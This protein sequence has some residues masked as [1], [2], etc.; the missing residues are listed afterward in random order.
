MCKKYLI[1]LLFI[2]ISNSIILPSGYAY[3]A[4][5]E[6]SHDTTITVD[7]FSNEIPKDIFITLIY[8]YVEKA[9]GDYYSKFMT[10]LPGEDPWSYMILNIKK[11]PEHN[12]SYIISLE[13]S[14]YVGP[15]L[16][17]GTDH[18]TLRID[19]SGV[20]IEKFEHI[21]SY[22]LPPHYQNILKGKWPA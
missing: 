21:K 2:L 8:P 7:N 9:I 18:I 22:P 4:I 15:H 1:S 12:Y 6:Y 13:V 17:V 16:S 5:S 14:P 19:L 3:G 11:L 10:Y 20:T